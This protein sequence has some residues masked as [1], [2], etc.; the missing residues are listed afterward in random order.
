[1]NFKLTATYATLVLVGGIVLVS[2][3]PPYCPPTP[4]IWD[5]FYQEGNYKTVIEQASQVVEAGPETE[6]YAEAVLYLGLAELRRDGG[7]LEVT[8][9]YLSEAE[10][11]VDDLTTIDAKYERPLLYR[12]LMVTYAK[13]GDI[14]KA[15]MYLELAIEEVPAQREE[16]LQEFKDAIS[17]P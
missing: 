2:C 11:L 7:D 13:L 5:N 3:C 9:D 17:L 8:L 1:M 12:G 10:R 16:I 15:E 4:E 14:D 6:F